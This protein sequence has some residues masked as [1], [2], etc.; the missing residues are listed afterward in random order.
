MKTT[1]KLFLVLSLFTSIALADGNQGGGGSPLVEPTK[2]PVI[3]T[4]V[5]ISVLEQ[6]L[7]ISF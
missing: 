1:L 7:G 2:T 6:Y 3:I 5:V 4:E